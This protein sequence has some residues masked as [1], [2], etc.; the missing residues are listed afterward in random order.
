MMGGGEAMIHLLLQVDIYVQFCLGLPV[1]APDSRGLP[2]EDIGH[3]LANVF[4]ISKIFIHN[5][6]L[7]TKET[8]KRNNTANAYHK[9]KLKLR[10]YQ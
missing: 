7:E 6:M 9:L 1:V 8:V 5:T 3:L 10:I 2:E 4:Q